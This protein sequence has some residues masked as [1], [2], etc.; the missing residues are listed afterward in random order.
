MK[1]K[2]T[3]PESKAW[4]YYA[5]VTAVLVY[6]AC[7]IYGPALHGPFVYDDFSLPY[8]NPLFP[9][10]NLSAWIAGVRPLLLLSYWLNFHFSGRE[11]F[12]YHVVNLLLHLGNATAVYLIARRILTW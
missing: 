3:L 5:A 12:S 1:V 4:P 8:Y 11:T 10:Q 9:N 2:K 7:E 6:I